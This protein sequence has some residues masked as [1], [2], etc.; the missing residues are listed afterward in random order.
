MANLDA[1]VLAADPRSRLRIGGLTARERAIRVAGRVGATRVF[2]VDRIGPVGAAPSTLVRAHAGDGAHEAE[3]PQLDAG[4]TAELGAWRGASAAPLLVIRADQLVHPPL[5]EPLVAAAP[6]LRADGVA[7]A[8]ANA[9][10]AAGVPPGD[11]GYGGAFLATGTAAAA[12]LAQLAAGTADA[13]I[14][15]ALPGTARVDVPYRGVARAAIGTAAERRSA[16]RLLYQILVKPQDNAITRYLYRPV[17]L[18]LTRLLVWTPVTP[19]QVSL[20]VAVIV[21]VGCWLTARASATSALVGTV[22]VLAASYLDCCD[23]EIARVKL[24]SSKL[25]AWLDTVIDELSSIAYIA[26]LGWHCHLAYDPRYPWVTATIVGAVVNAW[27]MYC[28]YFNIIV[29]VGSAN[30]QDYA[31]RF[32][33][34]P[35][36]APDT[37]RLAPIAQAI[38]PSASRPRWLEW[39]ATYLPYIARRDFLSWMAV[40]LTAVHA[41]HVLFVIF[42]VGTLVMTT[43]LTVD[44][45]W[46]RRLRRSVERGGK[47]MLPAR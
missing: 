8:V 2:V 44:H 24:T 35:G 30:S 16:H 37:V 27:A 40:A 33:V 17:S 5:V 14:V 26:A 38:A 20:A 22:V 39:A 9:A 36:E 32:T 21:A 28:V 12:A 6:A 42:T 46:L 13:A 10:G 43:V 41:A 47:R 45:L 19:N 29:G 15:D 18:P 25:G 1:I 3:R 23:G 31:G 11:H 7:V 4:A 34:R